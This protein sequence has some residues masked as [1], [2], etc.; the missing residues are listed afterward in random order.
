MTLLKTLFILLTAFFIVSCATNKVGL[1]EYEQG[2]RY[3]CDIAKNDAWDYKCFW[4]PTRISPATK[5]R[6][7]TESLKN[8]GKSELFIAG[9]YYEYERTYLNQLHLKC[10][11]D[12]NVNFF[13]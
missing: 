11:S 10:G 12:N 13:Q 4:Y 1:P 7:Y 6:A 5:A 2:R 3:A 8:Q 9:F